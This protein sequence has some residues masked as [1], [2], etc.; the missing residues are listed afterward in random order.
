MPWGPDA[1]SGGIQIRIRWSKTIQFAERLLQVPLPYLPRH[2]LCPVTAILQAFALTRGASPRGPAFVIPFKGEWIPFPPGRFIA[3]LRT[4]LGALGLNPR[5]FSGHSFRR[6]A[7]T[8]ALKLGLPGEIIKILG[9]WKSDA[10]LNYL[11]LD[12]STKFQSI[13]QFA[14][15]LPYTTLVTESRRIEYPLNFLIK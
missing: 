1:F 15:P 12:H 7:A 11:S 2:P 14:V 6:G 4:H 5:D 10:Y 13:H 9:D 3:T 8:W